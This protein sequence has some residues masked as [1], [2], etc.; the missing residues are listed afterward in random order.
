VGPKNACV[1][2]RIYVRLDQREN[3]CGVYSAFGPSTS[4]YLLKMPRPESARVF[5]GK[6][7]G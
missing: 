5:R 1:E 7:H 4:K 2:T 3:A 6:L